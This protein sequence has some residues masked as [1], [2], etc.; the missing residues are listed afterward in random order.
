MTNKDWY[1]FAQ[2][3]ID[4]LKELTLETARKMDSSDDAFVAMLKLDARVK[5]ME[6]LR[7]Y[8]SECLWKQNE[9]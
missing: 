6:D 8:V 2:E 4:Q 9:N 5:A 1:E 7:D 3:R